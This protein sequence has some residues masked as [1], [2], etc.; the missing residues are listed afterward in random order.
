VDSPCYDITPLVAAQKRSL[1]PAGAER[2]NIP[3]E[4][5][6]RHPAKIDWWVGIAIIGGL[7]L[8]VVSAVD[9]KRPW[10]WAASAGIWLLVFGLCLPQSYETTAD[11]LVV[12]SG[13]LRWRIPYSSIAAVRPSLDTR[14]SVALSLDRVLIEY[15]S[16]H[17]LIAPKDQAAFFAD[18]AARAPHLSRCGDDLVSAP[19]GR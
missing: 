10:A 15:D 8:P 14:S 16:K 5:V 9:S 4:I 3:G 7:V 2:R 11:S 17:L 12:R 1:L 19:T 18:L 6:M 13:L